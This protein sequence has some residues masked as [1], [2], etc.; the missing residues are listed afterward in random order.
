MDSIRSHLILPCLLVL[1]IGAAAAS[2]EPAPAAPATNAPDEILDTQ[3][4]VLDPRTLT[5]MDRLIDAISDRRVVFVGESHD[6]YED[7][8]NQLAVI[9]GLHRRGKDLAIGMEFFQQPFQG[10]LDA[11]IAGEIDEPEFLRQTEYFER[12]RY[13]F[14]LYRPILRFARE[15]RIPVIALNLESELTE[16]VGKG[17][18]GSLTPEEQAR[19]PADIDRE[20]P[21]YRDRVKR[22]FDMH[23]TR[24]DRAFEHFLEVQ[25][26]WDEG[27]AER[28][29]R[30]LQE[31]PNKTLV[32]LAG[33]GHIEFG[34]GI[35]R[36]VLRRT[37]VAA[38]SLLNGSVRELDPEAADY[39]LYPRRVELPAGGL[40]G[41]MLGKEI[42]DQ[43]A[44]VQ[45]F[46]EDSG[47]KAAGLEEGDQILR[48]GDQPVRGYADIRIALMDSRPGQRIPV[49]VRRKHVIGA[50]EQLTFEVEL[51]A[52]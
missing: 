21:V 52:Y 18:I 19:I 35:P 42:D 43:G 17:G 1:G 9:E 48:I 22:V 37:P 26:L 12:W 47:A 20:D 34:Q 24:E 27:M 8:L 36:R 2:P 49:E 45:G 23:P 29:A 5:D 4:R 51:H 44:R 30:Y 10:A 11:F 32:V 38:A 39:L 40:L 15:H 41:V 13:D 3:T 46:A 31:H 28:A 14:R 33:A 50:D 6:R 7:H 16:K 25:L